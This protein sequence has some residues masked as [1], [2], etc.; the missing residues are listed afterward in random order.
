M[1][2]EGEAGEVNEGSQPTEGAPAKA[3]T[4]APQEKGGEMKEKEKEKEKSEDVAP[5][6]QP[7][8]GDAPAPADPPASEEPGK[9]G[10]D[11]AAI[12][13]A[14]DGQSQPAP[15]PAQP[16]EAA[17]TH[18]AKKEAEQGKADRTT[19]ASSRKIAVLGLPYALGEGDLW[20]HMQEKFGIIQDAQL[21][22]DKSTG[23]SKGFAFVVFPT[24]DQVK[25]AIEA[26]GKFEIDGRTIDIK[27]AIP[28][29]QE[30]ERGQKRD[31]AMG[32]MAMAPMPNQMP[33]GPPM[34]M[35][36]SK[37]Y[38]KAVEQN[39]NL[40][41]RIFIAKIAPDTEGEQVKSY[42]SSFGEIEDFYM[43]RSGGSQGE[44]L[45]F[46]FHFFLGRNTDRALLSLSLSLSLSLTLSL[47]L[48]DRSAQRHRVP[49]LR[50]Q[51]LC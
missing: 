30:G 50:P 6:P 21:V 47:S 3:E 27:P 31:M 16:A 1:A 39:R 9:E 37:G 40:N 12:A 5:A 7:A 25:K 17:P 28:K 24:D 8:Q 15:E 32:N 20:R 11:G 42:F 43:P 45:R 36:N 13:K 18:P 23:R 38:N 10:D 26:S 35:H 51:L 33:P 41:R 29:G 34:G 4:E 44:P 48:I 2:K 46:F 22:T 14:T 49:D 19:P